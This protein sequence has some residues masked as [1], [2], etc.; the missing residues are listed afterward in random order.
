MKSEK[1]K[2][3]EIGFEPGVFSPLHKRKKTRNVNMQSHAYAGGAFLSDVF[4][5]YLFT[6][7]QCILYFFLLFYFIIAPVHR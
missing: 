1:A 2:K 4:L 6:F 5:F 3:D 7:L